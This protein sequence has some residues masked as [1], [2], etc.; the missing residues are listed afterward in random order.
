MRMSSLLG[1]AEEMAG[2]NTGVASPVLAVKLYNNLFGERKNMIRK[3][4]FRELPF[5]LTLTEHW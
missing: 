2:P 4:G 3:R 1:K 5:C